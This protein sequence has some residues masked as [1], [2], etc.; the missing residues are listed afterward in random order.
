LNT[1]T[2]ASRSTLKQKFRLPR[3]FANPTR[4]NP[5]VITAKGLAVT[6]VV[7]V[8]WCN[9]LP[10]GTVGCPLRTKTENA[11]FRIGTQPT[12]IDKSRLAFTEGDKYCSLCSQH[13]DPLRTAGAR[14]QPLLRLMGMLAV[15]DNPYRTIDPLPRLVYSSFLVSPDIH[16]F[17]D[18]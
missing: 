1:L 13:H 10:F 16:P 14:L 9:S 7:G 17:R 4:T 5:Q 18:G 3:P 2:P 15:E 6:V 8:D 11:G 12:K